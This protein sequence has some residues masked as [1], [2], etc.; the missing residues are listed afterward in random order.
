M[1]AF[2]KS[3]KMT[4]LRFATIFFA[5]FLAAVNGLFA[6]GCYNHHPSFTNF[7]LGCV[8]PFACQTACRHGQYLYAAIQAGSQCMCSNAQI[9]DTAQLQ[10]VTNCTSPCQGDNQQ[11]CGGSTNINVFATNFGGSTCS[12]LECLP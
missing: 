12:R 1:I 5:I 4:S 9:L 2:C 10:D 3:T 11:V 6:L 8:E 7:I